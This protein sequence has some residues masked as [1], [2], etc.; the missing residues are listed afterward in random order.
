MNNQI[1]TSVSMIF[2]LTA[3][4]N[5]YPVTYDSTPQSASV[6]CNGETKGFTPL[7]LYYEKSDIPET[8]ILKTIPCK[9]IWASGISTDFDNYFNTDTFPNGV[10]NTVQRPNG[11]GYSIDSNADYQKKASDKASKPSV[12]Y[13]PIYAPKTTYCNKIG[14]QVFCNS[15]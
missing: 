10:K 1:I 13:Q 3:C 12:N 6:V 2:L 15:Y 14:T 7:T 5:Q 9:A 11:D 8:G 4:S